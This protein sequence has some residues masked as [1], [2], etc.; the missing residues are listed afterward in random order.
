[1]E[2][3]AQFTTGRG[4]K[5]RIPG[6]KVTLEKPA[7]IEKSINNNFKQRHRF[8]VKAVFL[9]FYIALTMDIFF[10]GNSSLLGELRC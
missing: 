2:K 7:W 8:S 4:T 1:M 3:T 6:I 5:R 9:A 10:P